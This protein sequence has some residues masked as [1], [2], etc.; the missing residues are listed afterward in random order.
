MKVTVKGFIRKIKE[1]EKDL[2]VNYGDKALIIEIYENLNSQKAKDQNNIQTEERPVFEGI[3]IILCR[4]HYPSNILNFIQS[5]C[6]NRSYTFL[7]SG[8]LQKNY[9]VDNAGKEWLNAKIFNPEII[10]TPT[11]P[12]QDENKQS[13]LPEVW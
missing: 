10:I 13:D 5:E 1:N 4:S 8:I 2:S 9:T 3:K 11:K 6:S 12:K 7:F